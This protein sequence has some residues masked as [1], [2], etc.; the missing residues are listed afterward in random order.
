MQI[1]F[2]FPIRLKVGGM[3]TMASLEMAVDTG[4]A[5][6]MSPLPMFGECATSRGGASYP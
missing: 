4:P 5:F 6:S 3:H 2:K 1:H